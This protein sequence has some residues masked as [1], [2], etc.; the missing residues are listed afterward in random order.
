MKFWLKK[1]ICCSCVRL[2]ISA[3][4]RRLFSLFIAPHLLW[5]IHMSKWRQWNIFLENRECL[6]ARRLLHSVKNYLS[7]TSLLKLAASGINCSVLCWL[8]SV[9]VQCWC[10]LLFCCFK[11]DYSLLQL[12]LP[13]CR[14]WRVTGQIQMFQWA[15]FGLQVFSLTYTL[16]QHLILNGF[17]S[18]FKVPNV[19]QRTFRSI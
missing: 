2:L 4:F 13:K 7:F 12:L 18:N 1:Q 10:A 19:K 6:V 17:V 9:K 5:W 3:T 14:I 15:R 16:K 8:V 11:C